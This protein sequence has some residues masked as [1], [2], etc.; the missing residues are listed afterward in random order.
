[1]ALGSHGG[2]FQTTALGIETLYRGR[3]AKQ[4]G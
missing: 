2:D 1:M 4:Q 3:L